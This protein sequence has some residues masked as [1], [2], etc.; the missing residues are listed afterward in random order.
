[1]KN[2]N[3]LPFATFMI[4]VSFATSGFH[5]I[6]DVFN[7]GMLNKIA[8]VAIVGSLLVFFLLFLVGQIDKVADRMPERDANADM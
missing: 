3:L 5:L 8:V 4:L 2:I 1:M 6:E 7:S